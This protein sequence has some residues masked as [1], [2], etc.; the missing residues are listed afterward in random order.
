MAVDLPFHQTPPHKVNNFNIY[1]YIINNFKNFVYLPNFKMN[2]NCFFI[3]YF[4]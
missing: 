3:I 1:K 4:Q 2:Y